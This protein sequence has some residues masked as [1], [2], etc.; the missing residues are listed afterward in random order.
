[1]TSSLVLLGAAAGTLVAQVVTVVIAFFIV[2]LILAKV[3]W[4][5]V[6]AL[7][8]ERRKTIVD[9]FERLD[10]RQ[11]DLSS[12]IK[13]YEARLA[14]IDAEARERSN[15]AIE[16][17]K[18]TANEIIDEAKR[19]ADE[20]RTKAQADIRME[21]DK[22]RVELRSQMVSLTIGATERLLHAELNDERHRQLTAQ[23]IDD[24]AKVSE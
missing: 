2:L 17:G 18:R 12:K 5:P 10:A 1:M 4:K 15:K 23:F 22:A 8:D 6:I 21:I 19:L 20:T 3:A 14:Q 7:I 16:E 24:L 11:A 13:D 9:E